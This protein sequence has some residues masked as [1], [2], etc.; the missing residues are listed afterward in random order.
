[1][2]GDDPRGPLVETFTLPSWRANLP[3]FGIAGLFLGFGLLGVVVNG[4]HGLELGVFAA[5]VLATGVA[6][7]LQRRAPHR[8]A[9]HARGFAIGPRFVPWSLI[10]TLERPTV[11]ARF[12]RIGLDFGGGFVTLPAG[13]VADRAIALIEE[14][15]RRADDPDG[16]RESPRPEDRPPPPA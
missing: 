5:G 4:A 7:W 1:V 13:A 10:Q 15:R 6:L 8:L 14:R 11:R 3:A 12:Y 16:S 9:V 2:S